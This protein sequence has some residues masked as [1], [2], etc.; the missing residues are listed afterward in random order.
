MDVFEHFFGK[1][2]NPI[3]LTN[4]VFFIKVTKHYTEYPLVYI[5]KVEASTS[6]AYSAP[7]ISTKPVVLQ[8]AILLHTHHL[9]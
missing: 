9:Q 1:R 8:V 5:S 3:Y 6:K 2:R 7:E 4:A